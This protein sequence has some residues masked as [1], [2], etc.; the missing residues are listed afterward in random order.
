MLIFSP[1]GHDDEGVKE[2]YK[3]LLGKLFV[4]IYGPGFLYLQSES[5]DGV[6]PKRY[7]YSTEN[8]ESQIALGVFN[9]VTGDEDLYDLKSVKV[10]EGLRSSKL[11]DMPSHL[12][13]YTTRVTAPEEHL[14][15][16]LSKIV[17]IQY[18][19]NTRMTHCKYWET[20]TYIHIILENGIDIELYYGGHDYDA[21]EMDDEYAYRVVPQIVKIK[22][23]YWY[24][25]DPILQEC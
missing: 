12:T 24:K 21:V 6:T 1:H 4:N 13:T 17:E 18:C 16:H 9:E 14:D 19:E 8:M 10:V 7:S 11:D 22:E 5:R 23:Q 20:S 15:P 25:K 2:I 3:N